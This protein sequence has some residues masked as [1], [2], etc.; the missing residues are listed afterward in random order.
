MNLTDFAI[1]HKD[2]AFNPLNGREN[3][4]L[5]H[6]NCNRSH[7]EFESSA[8]HIPR[9]RESQVRK[10]FILGVLDG[11]VGNPTSK[12]RAL[13][14]EWKMGLA[15]VPSMDDWPFPL[16]VGVKQEQL[17]LDK[18]SARRIARIAPYACGLGSSKTYYEYLMEDMESG[19][20]DGKMIGREWTL[21]YSEDVA[22][23]VA[24]N[25]AKRKERHK[26]TQEAVA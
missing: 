21:S 26:I 16:L 3:T 8:P 22:H 20:F 24:Y 10:G 17:R 18:E 13:F 5:S 9:E 1:H 23:I 11:R 12:Q 6:P 14:D 7:N 25:L 4:A 2:K 15:T 19:V